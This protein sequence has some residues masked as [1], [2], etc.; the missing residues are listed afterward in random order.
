MGQPGLELDT[1][2]LLAQTPQ[3]LEKR[4]VYCKLGLSHTYVVYSSN[5]ILLIEIRELVVLDSMIALTYDIHRML[6]TCKWQIGVEVE[7]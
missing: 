2:G 4:F 5:Q 7:L 3:P 1:T 6:A